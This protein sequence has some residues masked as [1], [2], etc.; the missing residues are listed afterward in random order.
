VTR[1]PLVR[2]RPSPGYAPALTRTATTAGGYRLTPP[3]AAGLRAICPSAADRNPALSRGGQLLR[4]YSTVP[5]KTRMQGTVQSRPAAARAPGLLVLSMLS[6]SSF[7]APWPASARRRRSWTG[8]KPPA[9]ARARNGRR[10]DCGQ[11]QGR[12]PYQRR[13]LADRAGG[14]FWWCHPTHSAASCSCA[15]PA[16]M[17]LWRVF[18]PCGAFSVRWSPFPVP[19][20]KTALRAFY[21]WEAYRTRL[22]CGCRTLPPPSPPC[23][24]PSFCCTQ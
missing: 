1:R 13:P 22:A 18:R 8:G 24:P 6:D 12:P 9:K 17:P 11:R 5:S 7:N 14:F 23:L 10:P 19:R 21:A 20:P 2:A 16:A 4:E 15:R 3:H